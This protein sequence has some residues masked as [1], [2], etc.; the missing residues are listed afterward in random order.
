MYEELQTQEENI[1]DTG[2]DKILVLKN[3]KGNNWDK[4]LD[5]VSE[6]VNSAKYYDYKKVAEELRKFIPEYV[7]DAK[8]L[9]QR[10]K[11]SILDEN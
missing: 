10:L 6:I 11:S 8:T 3:G 9:K 5:D 1:I 4:L 7:P 2:H